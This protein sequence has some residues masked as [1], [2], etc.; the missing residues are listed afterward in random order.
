MPLALAGRAAV[1]FLLPK[2]SSGVFLRGLVDVAYLAEE[3]LMLPRLPLNVP[4]EQTDERLG[5][6]EEALR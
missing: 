5:P 3:N 4:L 1:R 6:G 2:E